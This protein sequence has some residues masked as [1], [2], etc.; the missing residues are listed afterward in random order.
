MTRAGSPRQ[1]IVSRFYIILNPTANREGAARDWERARAV[2][3]T[4]GAH[5]EVVRTA[6]PGH[7]AV[8]A[9]GAARDGWPAVIAAGGDGTVHE[10]ANGLLRVA[11]EDA[12]ATIPLGV[13]GM[14]SGND[15]VKLLGLPGGDPAAAARLLLEGRPR[16]VDV[17]W[18]STSGPGVDRFFIN[19]VG[20]GLD[21]RVAIETRQIHRLRGVAI[22]A[23]ALL[24]VLRDHRTPRM[25]VVVDGQEIANRPLTLVTA[26]NGGCHGGGFWICPAARVDDGVL[27]ICVADALSPFGVLRLVPRVMRGTHVGRPGVKIHRARRLRISSPDPLPVHADGEIISE[28]TH[29]VGIELLPDRLTVLSALTAGGTDLATTA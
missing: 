21:A 29:E 18:V 25:R 28:G 16:R 27:D 22:Y 20:V 11:G 19:G 10:V 9:E 17:G 13:I 6:A 1:M 23:W 3:D 2:L 24:R 5:Y 26:A 8:L 15:F 14:G 4:A 12:G 7:A